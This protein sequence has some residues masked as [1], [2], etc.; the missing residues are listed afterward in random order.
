MRLNTVGLIVPLALSLLTAPDRLLKH[1]FCT[2]G[3]LHHS[4]SRTERSNKGVG[5]FLPGQALIFA[6]YPIW[7]ILGKILT[8]SHDIRWPSI[9]GWFAEPPIMQGTPLL[10][11]KGSTWQSRR[12]PDRSKRHDGPHREPLGI[13]NSRQDSTRDTGKTGAPG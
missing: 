1:I 12:K 6:I 7:V 13:R 5:Y 10:R 3:V 8:A 4:R 9:S 11:E 2:C